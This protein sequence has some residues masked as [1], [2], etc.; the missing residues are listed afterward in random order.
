[1]RV[2]PGSLFATYAH[3]RR[4]QFF[5]LRGMLE[6]G[7]G[8]DPAGS[9]LCSPHL[10]QQRPI[11]REGCTILDKVGFRPETAVCASWDAARP[12]WQASCRR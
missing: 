1:M 12:A 5:V 9:W 6:E 11:S 4:E 3:P 8:H 7:Y 2:V 10:D